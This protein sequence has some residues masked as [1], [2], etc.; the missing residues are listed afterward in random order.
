MAIVA[1]LASCILLVVTIFGYA[2]DTDWLTALTVLFLISLGFSMFATY[3]NM[4]NHQYS[5]E[6]LETGVIDA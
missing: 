3:L 2:L 5:Y 1:V 4:R 6:P